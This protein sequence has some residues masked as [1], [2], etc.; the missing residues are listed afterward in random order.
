MI[1]LNK[2]LFLLSPGQ[3]R[4]LIVLTV[5]LLI[6]MMFEM[7]GLGILLPAL[8][9]MLKADIG[10]EY[11][12]LK[13]YLVSLGNPTQ[14][15]LVLWGMASLVFLYFIKAIFLVYL[16]WKQSGFTSRLSADLSHKLFL[17]Y[18]RLP[19]VF[20]LQRNSAELLRN[21]QGEIG[22]FTSLSQSIINLTT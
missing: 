15:V 10:K 13:P 21:I 2:I 9:L 22:M 18:L 6:G 20:H 17:G 1:F 12:A 3:K 4:S 19:Y 11:P 5:L 14:G 8:S 7:L 16:T